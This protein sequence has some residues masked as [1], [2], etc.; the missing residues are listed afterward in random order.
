LAVAETAR[1]Q[2]V[3]REILAAARR[4]WQTGAAGADATAEP[5]RGGWRLRLLRSGPRNVAVLAAETGPDSA[6]EQAAP[7][8]LNM[9]LDHIAA[10]IERVRLA[11]AIEEA[12]IEA[13]TEKLREALLNSISHDLKTPLASILGAATALQSFERIDDGAA[14][15]DLTATIRE[16]AERLNQFIGNVLDLSRIRAG[17]LRARLEFVELADIVDSALRRAQRA[18]AGHEV[19]VSLPADLPM[20]HLDLFLM[21]HALVNILENAAKYS[22]KGTP[23]KL[24]AAMLGREIVLEIQDRGA[25]IAT[26]ELELIFNQFYRADVHDAK[27]AGTGLGLA[28]CR[29]FV[30][31][32]G[33]R[34]EAASAGAQRGAIF[35]ITLP[36]PED[37][38]SLAAELDE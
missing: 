14:R 31:A 4:L 1:E 26:G 28:I 34:I 24:S 6:L 37:A 19:D 18:L 23:I 30:E 38:A 32:N 8:H 17:E 36:I 25:G 9:L 12:R 10:T 3:E 20:L 16:E 21:E 13:K 5:V 7:A 15:T 2:P 29:S 11:A 27:P 35:R 22:E 33:G